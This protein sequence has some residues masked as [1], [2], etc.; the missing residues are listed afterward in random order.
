M[1]RAGRALFDVLVDGW[2]GLDRLSI[3]CGR[4]NNAGDGYVV[5]ELALRHGID[6]ELIQ[7]GD[8]AALSGDAATAR[9]DALGAGLT[10]LRSENGRN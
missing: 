7:L 4:G 9:D 10:I 1:R 3:C 2:P 6:V 8:P 5:A